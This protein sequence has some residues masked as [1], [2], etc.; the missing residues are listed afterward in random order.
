MKGINVSKLFI[1]IICT[2]IIIFFTVVPLKCKPKSKTSHELYV[3][4]HTDK[5]L[6]PSNLPVGKTIFIQSIP[7]YVHEEHLRYAYQSVGIISR[8]SMANRNGIIIARPHPDEQPS[9]Y[10]NRLQIPDEFKSAYISFKTTKDMRAA[11]DVDELKLFDKYHNALVTGVKKWE[12]N[13]LESLPKEQEIS[14]EVEAYMKEFEETE[15]KEK[16][17]AKRPEVDDDGWQVVKKGRGAGFE[18]KESTLKKLE[19]KIEEGRKKK[20]LG[21]FYTFQIRE[22][23]QKHIVGLRRRFEDDKRKVESMKKTRQFKPY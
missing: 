14:A 8:V 22:S 18:K 21:N 13:Y 10:F 23:K 5:K 2:I 19:D 11:L 17:E 3:K 1:H 4:E 15:E 9:K 16:E 6:D 12:E 7:P 20:E